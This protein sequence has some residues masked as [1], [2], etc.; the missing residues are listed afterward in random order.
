MKIYALEFPK[1]ISTVRIRLIVR[2][3]INL[4]VLIFFELIK[5]IKF[6]R[7]LLALFIPLALLD[8]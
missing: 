8:R 1:I 4:K 2:N 5:T 3:I 7:L 6:S